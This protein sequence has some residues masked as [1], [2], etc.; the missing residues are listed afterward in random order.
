MKPAVP[1]RDLSSLDGA[2]HFSDVHPHCDT[3]HDHYNAGHIHQQ[4]R[5]YYESCPPRRTVVPVRRSMS[6][7]LAVGEE[8]SCIPDLDQVKRSS[9]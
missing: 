8:G 3:R 9:L 7:G 5:R 4:A 1:P 6:P 2:V